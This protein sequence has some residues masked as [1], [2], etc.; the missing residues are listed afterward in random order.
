VSVTEEH[1][2][3]ETVE[4]EVRLVVEVL[5]PDASAPQ[6]DA[7]AQTEHPDA[8]A[9]RQPGKP[10]ES[11]RRPARA[12]TEDEEQERREEQVEVFLDGY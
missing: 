8:D 7:D 2:E 11:T 1:A 12:R 4:A 3:K 9:G 5:P 10:G 6:V